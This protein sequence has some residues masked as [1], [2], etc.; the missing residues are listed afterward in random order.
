[1]K[2]GKSFKKRKCVCTVYWLCVEE[3]CPIA[4]DVE[5]SGNIY[6]SDKRPSLS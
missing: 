6:A 4:F 2:N 3:Y 5:Y 1:M